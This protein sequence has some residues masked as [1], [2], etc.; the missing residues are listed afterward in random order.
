MDEKLEKANK[1]SDAING[2]VK[3]AVIIGS[4]IG[5]CFLFYFQVQSNEQAIK[6]TNKEQEDHHATIMNEFID[7]GNRSNNR[8]KRILKSIDE[9]E[10]GANKKLEWLIDI[11]KRLSKLEGKL[12]N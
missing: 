2:W 11:E 7:W 10:G 8:N 5:A 12:N 3:I 9:I 1:L 4:F 6:L